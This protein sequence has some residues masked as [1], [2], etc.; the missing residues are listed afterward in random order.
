MASRLLLIRHAAT[1]AAE[2]RLLVGSTEVAAG[3]A[4]LRRLARFREVLAPFAPGEWYSSPMKRAVQTASGIVRACGL[5]CAIEIDERLREI[6]FGRWEMKSIAD[7]SRTEPDMF[8]AWAEYENFVFPKG[9]AVAHFRSRVA[10]V[11]STLRTRPA[12]EI[13]VVTHGGV[14]RTMICLA[15]G[16]SGKNYLLYNVQPGS[17]TV[18]DLY[19]EGG[20]L[21]GLNL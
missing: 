5:D 21:A 17:L 15:L 7:L 18:L 12:Q 13:A 10:D 16:Q 8:D 3:K 11:F 14:I 9:E 1:D 19:P 2:K 4:G 20:V 6:D